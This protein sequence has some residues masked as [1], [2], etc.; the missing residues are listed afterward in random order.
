MKGMNINMIDIAYESFVNDI[1]VDAAME[2]S[3][4]YGLVTFIKH[5]HEET[6]ELIKKDGTYSKMCSNFKYSIISC[7]NQDKAIHLCEVHIDELNSL[8]RVARNVDEGKYT[9]GE[10]MDQ[11]TGIAYL[12]EYMTQIGVLYGLKLATTP[13]AIPVTIGIGAANITALAICKSDS[14][15]LNIAI[16]NLE[17]RKEIIKNMMASIKNSGINADKIKEYID[18]ADAIKLASK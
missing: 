9:T 2:E 3:K 1:C 4:I 13:V 15:K 12:A 18:Q 14:I 16:K 11:K 8:I 7:K 10:N 17:K 5:M 6:K